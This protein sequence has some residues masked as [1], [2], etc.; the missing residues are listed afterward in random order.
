VSAARMTVCKQ[1]VTARAKQVWCLPC[2]PMLFS[3]F[4]F[5]IYV[6]VECREREHHGVRRLRRR[7]A[8]QTKKRSRARDESE[9]PCLCGNDCMCGTQIEWTFCKVSHWWR[10]GI[11]ILRF[12][13]WHAL[14]NVLSTFVG[15]A[16]CNREE[17]TMALKTI[18][19]WYK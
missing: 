10:R 4:F 1:L 8:W 14:E 11:N 13:K 18:H 3:L 16:N 19:L 9:C 17:P 6:I 12:G 2:Y 7:T 15:F 5:S